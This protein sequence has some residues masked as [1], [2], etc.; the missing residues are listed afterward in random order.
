M[1]LN[2]RE[3]M[4]Y[5]TDSM[6]NL[7]RFRNMQRVIQ[8][9]GCLVFAG[10]SRTELVDGKLVDV[11]ETKEEIKR[12]FEHAEVFMTHMVKKYGEL[13]VQK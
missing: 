5:S 1:E 11:P 12:K 10:A 8:H 4:F 6:R 2:G 7:I 3:N 13:P 9:N